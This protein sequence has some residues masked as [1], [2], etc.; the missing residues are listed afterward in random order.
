M[1]TNPELTVGIAALVAG[2]AALIFAVVQTLTAL[3]QY[4]QLSARCST[5]VTGVFNL[6]AGFW[7]HVSSLS[8]NPQYRMPVI[9]MPILRQQPTS[10][11]TSPQTTNFNDGKNYDYSKNGYLDY[12]VLRI[13]R[14][15]TSPNAGKKVDVRGTM[16]RTILAVMWTPIGIILS[17]IT[18]FVCIIPFLAC[19]CLPYTRGKGGGFVWYSKFGKDN[20]LTLLHLF[21]TSSQPLTFAWARATRYTSEDVYSLHS[22]PALEAAAW[23]QFLVNF[24]ETWW[25]RADIHWKWRLATMIPA[26]TYGASIES[27]MADVQLLAALAGMHT[28]WD[29]EVIARTKCGEMLT[30]SQHAALGK[31]VYY[32]S[33]RKNTWPKINLYG[34]TRLPALQYIMDAH[35][36]LRTTSLTGDDTEIR[37]SCITALLSRPRSDYDAQ[38][39]V[40]LGDLSFIFSTEVFKAL[41]NG[42][43]AAYPGWASE[44]VRV[45]FGPLGQGLGRCSCLACC[46]GWKD[47]DSTVE[48]KASVVV[49]DS[50]P[51]RRIY[52]SCF[53][54]LWSA[55]TVSQIFMDEDDSPD[56][57]RVIGPFLPTASN[58]DGDSDPNF[59]FVTYTAT[60]SDPLEINS[61]AVCTSTCVEG[62]GCT[63]GVIA[64]IPASDQPP[65]LQSLLAVAGINTRWLARCPSSLILEASNSMAAWITTTDQQD[66]I[67]RLMVMSSI[68]RAFDGSGLVNVDLIRVVM[69]YT[70]SLLREVRKAIGSND[71]WDS[72]FALGRFEDFGPVVLGA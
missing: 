58:C 47:A 28:T 26:D 27:T 18:L 63:C 51:K 23:C 11:G 13:A 55:L 15:Y 67:F 61:V 48:K 31:M 45:F 60:L 41:Y 39:D 2:L 53:Q 65:T 30:T 1:A 49:N 33:P 56:P 54:S 71:V 52:A 62:E 6:S 25:G 50:N 5:R 20:N 68:E 7:F 64:R 24:Q 19:G 32:R 8:W 22:S 9:T 44:Q 43:H 21:R 3:S 70:E 66:E 10:S 42:L 59:C 4:V 36:H 17:F 14:G 37:R 57:V 40:S 35:N 38:I 69:A 72:T 16:V 46:E 29:P 12:E 34:P